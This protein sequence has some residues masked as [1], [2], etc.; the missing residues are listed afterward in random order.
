MKEI[1]KNDC[2]E[3]RAKCQ[4][5]ICMHLHMPLMRWKNKALHEDIS[6][7]FSKSTKNIFLR[8]KIKHTSLNYFYI[9]NT[10]II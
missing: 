2:D 4:S 7:P 5:F 1:K 10:T 6:I 9:I 8:H 3:A